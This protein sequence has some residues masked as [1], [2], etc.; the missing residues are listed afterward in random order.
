MSLLS[1]FPL[2]LP[3]RLPRADADDSHS[4]SEA[5]HG[6][7]QVQQAQFRLRIVASN[8]TSKQTAAAAETGAGLK[9]LLA[10]DTARSEAAAADAAPARKLLLQGEPVLERMLAGYEDM[11]V[12]RWQ[13]STDLR[14]FLLELKEIIVS[15]STDAP[16][17]TSE[18]RQLT[19]ASCSCSS[20]SHHE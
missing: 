19:A 11:L 8:R 7:M 3:E 1:A 9:M 17:Q 16:R 2:L 10:I 20:D 4:I 18:Y 14:G 12:Q 15:G 13:Q 5:F 6:I